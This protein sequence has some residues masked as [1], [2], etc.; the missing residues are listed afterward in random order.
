MVGSQIANLTPDLLLAINCVLDCPN[1]QCESILDI[2]VPR[3]FQ[4]YKE[5]HKLLSF[6]PW[7]CSL[8]FQKSTETPSPKVKVALGV[9]DVTLELSLGLHP[10]NPFALVTSPRLRLWQRAKGIKKI[11][12]YLSFCFGKWKLKQIK[13]S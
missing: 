11:N 3:A 7:N 9:C 1:E 6:D 5:C 8:K 2:Y 13:N 12:S 4:W 10:C